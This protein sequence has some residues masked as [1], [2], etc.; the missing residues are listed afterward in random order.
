MRE[1]EEI[2]QPLPAIGGGDRAQRLLEHVEIGALRVLLRGARA[3][4]DRVPLQQA[5][6]RAAEPAG[7]RLP[8]P[9]AGLDRDALDP[10]GIDVAGGDLRRRGAEERRAL[11]G[12]AEQENGALPLL[13]G[14]KGGESHPAPRYAVPA[15]A[16]GRARARC[17]RGCR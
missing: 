2:G 17:G 12:G 8:E 1:P 6:R 3:G 4:H 15:P 11:L 14:K 9:D 5:A 13:P 16:A 7:E 10:R